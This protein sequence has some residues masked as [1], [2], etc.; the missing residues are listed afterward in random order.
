M[1]RRASSA[2]PNSRRAPTHR[3]RA[4]RARRSAAGRSRKPWSRASFPRRRRRSRPCP[5]RYPHPLPPVH[6]VASAGGAVSSRSSPARKHLPCTV[7][8]PLPTA[9]GRPPRE[10]EHRGD[11]RR[12][13]GDDR[14][15]GRRDGQRDGQ[16]DEKRP[17]RRAPRRQR[18]RAARSSP[19]S[20]PRALSATYDR[21]R[22]CSG[23]GTAERDGR[24]PG[25]SRRAQ[26]QTGT[27]RGND[28]STPLGAVAAEPVED[29]VPAG[30]SLVTPDATTADRNPRR[31][32]AS[33]VAVVA[34]AAA[35]TDRAAGC[36]GS[37]GR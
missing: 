31:S 32:V 11:R 12:G 19:R 18:R 30:A 7:R 4:A 33:A 23:E 37:G 34:V 36:D 24:R 6:P 15:D 2:P 10:A 20:A 28:H 5:R 26:G 14:R 21:L 17:A 8:D 1:S 25:T 9:D 13:R 3:I 29:A 35:V 22:R 27:A 16:R